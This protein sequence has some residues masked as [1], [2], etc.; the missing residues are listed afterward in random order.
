MKRFLALAVLVLLL[1][2]GAFGGLAALRIPPFHNVLP[3]PS[4]AEAEVP[5]VP[6]AD[7]RSLA[8]GTVGVP[9]IRNGQVL[10]RVF[11]TVELRV[12]MD[13]HS[14]VHNRL[15]QLQDAYL[16]DLAAFLPSRLEGRKVP[17]HELVRERLELVT[18]RVLGPDRVHEVLILAIFRR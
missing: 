1:G 12:H 13:L 11:V 9:V 3:E 5:A 4:E 17:D 14:H 10:A 18:E 16:S 2:G 7:L 15:L 6:E 8:V